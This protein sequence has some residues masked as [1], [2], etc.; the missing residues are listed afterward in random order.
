MDERWAGVLPRI[1][2]YI[3]ELESSDVRKTLQDHWKLYQ[4]T[5]WNK[6]DDQDE[7]L[8]AQ[9]EECEESNEDDWKMDIDDGDGNDDIP[10]ETAIDDDEEGRPRN[11]LRIC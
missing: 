8:S 3:Q 2:R 9:E 1:A 5:Y 7:N 10:E 6:V 11:S 4:K